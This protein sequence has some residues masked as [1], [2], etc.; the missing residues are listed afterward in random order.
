M[1]TLKNYGLRISAAVMGAG[2]L[3]MG[4]AALAAPSSTP[5]EVLGTVVD[6][7]ID[8]GVSLVQLVMTTYFKYILIFAIAVGFIYWV[9]RFSKLGSR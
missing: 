4:G 3:L 7:G 8:S 9:K 6:N 1:N 5:E 2:A